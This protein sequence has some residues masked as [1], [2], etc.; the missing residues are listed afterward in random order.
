[1]REKSVLKAAGEKTTSHI[2]GKYIRLTA[3]FSVET[4]KA[5][6]AW[7]NAFQVLKDYGSQIGLKYAQQ[8][9]PVMTEGEQKPFGDGKQPYVQQTKPKA[10]TGSTLKGV[11]VTEIIERNTKER[12]LIIKTNDHWEHNSNNQHHNHHS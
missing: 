9:Y 10:N 11:N 6:R 3:D 4:L 1:M 2:E 7:S 12:A 8:N 5:R